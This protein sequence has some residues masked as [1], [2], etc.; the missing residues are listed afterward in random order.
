MLVLTVVGFSGVLQ[1]VATTQ[2]YRDSTREQT[3]R[4]QSQARESGGALARLV[5]LTGARSMR[6]NDFG[7]LV[8]LAKSTVANDPNVLRT[9]IIDVDGNVVADTEPGQARSRP[10]G[11]G[12]SRS[13]PPSTRTSRC[14]STRCPSPIPTP[15]AAWW[16]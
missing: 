8:E 7:E 10:S 2:E 11:R 6:D 4:L 9:Q 16:S 14:S 13:A 1:I 3:M 5:A 15:R 12:R